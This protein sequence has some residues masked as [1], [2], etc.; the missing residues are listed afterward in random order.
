[1]PSCLFLWHLLCS[2]LTEQGGG[3][4]RQVHLV[5]PEVPEVMAKLIT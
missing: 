1:M 5:F 4:R 2:P 3:L